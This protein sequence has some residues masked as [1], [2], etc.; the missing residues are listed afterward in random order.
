[1]RHIFLILLIIFAFVFTACS[2]SVEF[3]VINESDS[4][5]E[6]RCK[7]VNLPGN[8][9]PIGVV[10]PLSLANASQLRSGDREW[11]RLSD[12]E[13]RAD[14]ESRSVTARVLP[15]EALLVKRFHD[16]SMQNGEPTEFPIEEIVI[17]GR[18]GEIKLQGKQTSKAFK[19][20]TERLYTLT[21]R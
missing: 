6:V 17:T 21:Y 1:M 15:G 11:R 4:P 9:D 5:I 16:S 7:I 8:P 13:Y 12:S 10:G 19:S 3:V 20:E 14:I 18:N 2:Y